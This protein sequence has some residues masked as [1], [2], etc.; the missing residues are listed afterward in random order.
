MGATGIV[1]LMRRRVWV[2]RH[3]A[4]RIAHVIVGR[5]ARRCWDAMP[6]VRAIVM[7]RTSRLRRGGVIALWGGQLLGRFVTRAAAALF[8]LGGISMRGSG[9]HRFSFRD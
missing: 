8:F 3:P 7:L 5:I 6:P 4:H 9:C 1:V 2:D